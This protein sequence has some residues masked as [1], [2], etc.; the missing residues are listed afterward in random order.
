MSPFD[1]VLWTV[2][3]PEGATQHCRAVWTRPHNENT[4]GPKV[5][6]TR[7]GLHREM[8]WPGTG[9]RRRIAGTAMAGRT[10]R[11]GGR[12]HIPPPDPAPSAARRP[13]GTRWKAARHR[14]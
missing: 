11:A 12:V 4:L 8:V 5:E 14:L 6:R 1:N 2:S 3:H 7:H 13:L 10:R 9:Q